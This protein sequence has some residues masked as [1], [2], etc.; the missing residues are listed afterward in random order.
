MGYR[1]RLLA[2]AAAGS[3]LCSL[4]SREIG[5]ERRAVWVVRTSIT[6][7]ERIQNMVRRAKDAG[8]NTLF[9]QVRGRGDAYY[10]SALEPRAE[11][12]AGKPADFDPLATTLKEAQKYGIEVH[13]W[14]NVMYL[15]SEKNPPVSAEHIVNKHPDWIAV[16]QNGKKG[17][18]LC[19]S[20]LEAR[21][22]TLAVVSDLAKRYDLAG[23]HLDYIRMDDPAYCRCDR[24]M[25][26][27][28]AT[29]GL[30][31]G[32]KELATTYTEA[33]AKWRKE[34]ITA[35]VKDIR[36]GLREGQMLTA[37]VWADQLRAV[38][39]KM[40]DWPRWCREGLLDAVVPMN[41]TQDRP[42]FARLSAAAVRSAGET[43]VWMGI[44]AWRLP[45]ADVKA[46]IAEAR[47]LN[48]A[49]FSLFSYGGI[50]QDGRSET[51]LDALR[52]ELT[53]DSGP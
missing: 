9:V 44:G 17:Q 1:L 5:E 53:S 36:A 2:L 20:C 21:D 26:A 19:P 12:L 4:G 40:Q 13:A 30:K 50:T 46:M 7:G 25:K 49:G 15:W 34:R 23:I 29:L 42:E 24:C 52:P 35:L 38:D 14:V 43:P 6:S 33:F 31:S 18:F 41:Y 37:A 8:F 3:A 27:F 48:L 47:R 22:H 51:F 39:Q 10:R 32:G 45:E 16:D 11:A 28:R